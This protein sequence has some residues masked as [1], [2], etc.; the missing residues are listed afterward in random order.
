MCM[1][2]AK[3]CLEIGRVNKPL[4]STLQFRLYNTHKQ[5]YNLLKA[6]PPQEAPFVKLT[7]RL[8][9][10]L[11][12]PAMEVFPSDPSL[13]IRRIGQRLGVF[14]NSVHL[15]RRRTFYHF[16]H[17]VDFFRVADNRRRHH[18]VFDGLLKCFSIRDQSGNTKQEVSLYR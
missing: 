4:Y 6:P 1:L 5:L 18:D 7:Q 10:C 16:G 13:Q 14:S 11:L 12:D 9:G 3:L 15:S 17:R 2:N 8:R